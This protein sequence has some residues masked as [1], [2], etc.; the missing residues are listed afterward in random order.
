MA[1][2]GLIALLGGTVGLI[3]NYRKNETDLKLPWV[4]LIS[5][6]LLSLGL[7]SLGILAAINPVEQVE[8]ARQLH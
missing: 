7:L 6:V 2:P 5:L 3:K 1:L 8:K 4:V